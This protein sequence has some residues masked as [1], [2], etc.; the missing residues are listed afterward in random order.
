MCDTARDMYW[1]WQGF[2]NNSLKWSGFGWGKMAK[3]EKSKLA[4]HQ[5][6]C[7]ACKEKQNEASPR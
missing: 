1:R 6:R 4:N 7:K 3:K 2:M 5:S